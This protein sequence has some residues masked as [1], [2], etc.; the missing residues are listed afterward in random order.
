MNTYP[1]ILYWEQIPIC[2]MLLYCVD[3]KLKGHIVH[4]GTTPLPPPPP[5]SP[6]HVCKIVKLAIYTVHKRMNNYPYIL[7]WEQIPICPMLLY[8][9]DEKLKGHIVH[10]G[11]TPLPP[12]PPYPQSMSAKLQNWQYTLN[13]KEWTPI[14]IYCIGNRFLY[15]PCYCIVLMKNLRAT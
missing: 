11:T 3:E 13:T 7:Y 10:N 12:P 8:C 2:P 6:K 1:Y 4:N 15:V 14:R 5:L 9:V